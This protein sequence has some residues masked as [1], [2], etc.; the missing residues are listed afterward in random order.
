M[1]EADAEGAG[2]QTVAVKPNGPRN[3]PLPVSANGKPRRG[4]VNLRRGSDVLGRGYP[5]TSSEASHL[6]TPPNPCR[7]DTR[8]WNLTELLHQGEFPAEEVTLASRTSREFI[9]FAPEGLKRPRSLPRAQRC[10]PGDLSPRLPPLPI[11]L[12]V[13]LRFL[14]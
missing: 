8:L 7:L 9:F 3:S 11:L 14:E 5:L 12:E 1:R 2:A 4:I 10:L 13:C 6:R